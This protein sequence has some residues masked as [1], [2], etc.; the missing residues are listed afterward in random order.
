MKDENRRSLPMICMVSKRYMRTKYHP[1]QI[2]KMCGSQSRGVTNCGQTV[3][4][5]MMSPNTPSRGL[6]LMVSP[7]H[8]QTS[9][10]LKGRSC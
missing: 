1:E 5:P 9:Q 2:L 4:V 6:Y 3:G 8:Q 7:T 10:M